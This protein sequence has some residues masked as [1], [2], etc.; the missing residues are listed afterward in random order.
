MKGQRQFP[1]TRCVG[2]NL[3]R[4][5]LHSDHGSLSRQH[6]HLFPSRFAERKSSMHTLYIRHRASHVF[7]RYAQHKIIIGFEHPALRL[8]Q[9]HPDSAVGCLAEIPALGVFQ[10]CPAADDGQSHII[11]TGSDPYAPVF[12]LGQMCQDESLPIQIEIIL[13]HRTPDHDTAPRFTRFDR[14]MRLGIVFQRLVVPD[15]FHRF[16]DRFPVD[17]LSLSE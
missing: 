5:F 10:V 3:A 7:L 2:G 4:V 6:R 9:S 14:Y 17:D 8:H 12:P 16:C 15:S 13:P 1:R 11:E